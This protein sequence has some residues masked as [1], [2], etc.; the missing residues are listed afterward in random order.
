MI[1]NRKYLRE[2]KYFKYYDIIKY[3]FIIYL[4]CIA[5]LTK[6]IS[7]VNYYNIS[8]FKLFIQMVNLDKY[9]TYY[10]YFTYF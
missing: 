7:D 5:I 4:S 10:I 6:H 3:C 9:P 8:Q 2:L 1:A